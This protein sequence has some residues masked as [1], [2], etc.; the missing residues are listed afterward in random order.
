[1]PTKKTSHLLYLT[2]IETLKNL[3]LVKKKEKNNRKNVK[4]RKELS[5]NKKRSN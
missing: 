3:I 5:M 1:M 2:R 4:K